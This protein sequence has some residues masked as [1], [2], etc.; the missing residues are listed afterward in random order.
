MKIDRVLVPC[1]FSESSRTA[2]QFACGLAQGCG[3][4]LCLAHA[5]FVPLDLEAM[6]VVGMSEVFERVE[7]EGR[8]RLAAWAREA[9]SIGL[10]CEIHA[11]SGVPEQVI[12]DLASEQRADLIVMGTSGRTGLAHLVL[13]SRAERVLRH[14]PCPVVTVSASCTLKDAAPTQPQE[15]VLLPDAQ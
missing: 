13:G 10:P 9:E 14:A 5:Y 1:D 11:R 2:F 4:R 6:S 7:A 3:A 15:P 8:N 12:L